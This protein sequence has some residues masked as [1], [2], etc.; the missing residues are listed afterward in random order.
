MR[1]ATLLKFAG[2]T[3]ASALNELSRKAPDYAPDNLLFVDLIRQCADADIDQPRKL[4]WAM[5]S[6]HTTAIRTYCQTGRLHSETLCGRTID[7]IN[8]LVLI[9]LWA[10]HENQILSSV[11]THFADSNCECL[12]PF[13][14]APGEVCSRCDVLAWFS[15]YHPSRMGSTSAPD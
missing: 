3:L 7:A 14:G 8:F 5:G 15:Q 11:Y 6:K 10:E 2:D 12:E 4:L 1:V 9:R 13:A